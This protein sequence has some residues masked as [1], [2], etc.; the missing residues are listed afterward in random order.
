MGQDGPTP[1]HRARA[2]LAALLLAALA[3]GLAARGGAQPGEVHGLVA[4]KLAPDHVKRSVGD[5]QY[6]TVLGE[7][8]DGR[9]RNVTQRV[10]YHSM[11]LAVAVARNAKG[12]KSKIEAVGVGK[13]IISATDPVTGISSAASNGNATM[14]VIGRL[15]RL[16]LAPA[17]VTR[18]VGEAQHFTAT[19]YYPGG[20]T[21]NL[22]QRVHYVSSNPLVA[23]APNRHGDKSRIEA[24]APGTATISARDLQTGLTTEQA[25]TSATMTVVGPLE[26]I[27]LAPAQARRAMGR[28]QHF[29]A[30]GHYGG[31][32]TKN[33][34]QQ[35]IYESSDR[36]VAKVRNLVGDKSRIEALAPGTVTI[37]ARDPVTG[38]RSTDS[39]SDAT[40]TVFDPNAPGAAPPA[41]A[42]RPAAALCGDANGDGTIGFADAFWIGAGA[43]GVAACPAAVC[44]VD[45]DGRVAWRDALAVGWVAVGYEMSLRCP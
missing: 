24:V 18:A 42:S 7:F 29:T 39:Q 26:K 41:P 23:L 32:Q 15:E 3:L 6:F 36:K 31:G 16:V 13:S 19:G 37:T 38:I 30:V 35:V 2:A 45:A 34:T 8:A 1:G 9:T 17:T 11:N 14:V 43:A 10:D 27:V 22:T 5:V 33:L 25:G 20:E 12:E 21:I 28:T 44:D 4:L 40:L